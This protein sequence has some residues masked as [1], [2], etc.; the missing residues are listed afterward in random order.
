MSA[1]FL[2]IEMQPSET[3]RFIAQFTPINFNH[4]L[5]PIV[6]SK[7]AACHRTWGAGAKLIHFVTQ[8][9]EMP[10]WLPDPGLLRFQ[11]GALLTAAEISTFDSW[12]RQGE[13]EGGN[14]KPAT[15][16]YFPKTWQLGT[17]DMTVN[18]LLTFTLPS[19]GPHLFWNFVLHLATRETRWLRD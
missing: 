1:H 15:I 8:N 9:R 10:P 4:D 18:A 3:T 2:A 11:G 7:C 14:T 5:A 16:A 13:L 17:P 19:S 6:F 12:V